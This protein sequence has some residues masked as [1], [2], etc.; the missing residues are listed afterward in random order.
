[1]LILLLFYNIKFFIAGNKKT[2]KARYNWQE[3]KYSDSISPIHILYVSSKILKIS[4]QGSFS[5]SATP[6]YVLS[7]NNQKYF[8]RF[9]YRTKHSDTIT[10]FDVHWLNGLPKHY[11]DISQI[12]WLDLSLKSP[13]TN[14]T[15]TIGDEFMCRGNA[16]FLRLTLNKKKHLKFLGPQKDVFNFGYLAR[17]NAKIPD[18][19]TY[20]KIAPQAQYY[21]LF[22]RLQ[23]NL[24]LNQFIAYY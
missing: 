4:A 8:F 13:G 18:L 23:D 17:P 7:N 10:F 21:I 6:T 22:F 14:T 1:M 9:E 12:K 16:E 3:I 20:A 24:E 15:V 19:V 11:D 5:P 2:E